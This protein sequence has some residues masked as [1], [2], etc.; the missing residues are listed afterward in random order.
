VHRTLALFLVVAGCSSG[1]ITPQGSIETGGNT[2]GL[3]FAQLVKGAKPD[4]AAISNTRGVVEVYSYDNTAWSEIGSFFAGGRAIDIAT[5][6]EGT[7]GVVA[8]R[9]D[10]GTVALL[11]AD[12]VNPHRLL[13]PY[14]VYRRVRNGAPLDATPPANGFALG[15]LD[16]DG[17][18]EVVVGATGL[19]LAIVPGTAIQQVLAANPE[20]P[21]PANG[22]AY[23]AGPQPGAVGL[24]DMDNDGLLDI[25]LLDQQ[26]AVAR[27]Y[28]NAGGYNKIK[29]PAQVKLPNVGVKVVVTGCQAFPVAVLLADGTLATISRDGQAQTVAADLKPIKTIASTWTSVVVTWGDKSSLAIFDACATESSGV[30]PNI[31][32]EHVANLAIGALGTPG[33]EEMALLDADGKTV[34]LY[35]ISGL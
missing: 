31:P 22:A 30:F 4:L 12:P 25:V 13:D 23:A 29:A 21:P 14:Q 9:W 16:K 35:Q 24:V 17:F 27:V 15:D 11:P 34:T 1:G 32:A 8:V 18:D 19:G 6:Q 33:L 10:E 28:G 7:A 5:G 3:G 2:I 20:K 26:E